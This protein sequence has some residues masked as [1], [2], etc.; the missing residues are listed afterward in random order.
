M[1]HFT[2]EADVTGK[3]SPFFRYD[4]IREIFVFCLV[5]F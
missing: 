4:P 2:T 5:V 1:D 3:I